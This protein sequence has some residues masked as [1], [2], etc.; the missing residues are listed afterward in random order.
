MRAAEENINTM[1]EALAKAQ[2]DYRIE[3][4]RY[5][6]GVGTNL[7]VMDAEKKLVSAKGDYISAL[8]KYNISKANLDTAMG[9]PVDL[10]V[11]PY[12]QAMENSEKKGE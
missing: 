10:D 7:E 12:R 9:V 3:V 4:V 6:A 1:S 8:Y 5:N 11:E 2:E